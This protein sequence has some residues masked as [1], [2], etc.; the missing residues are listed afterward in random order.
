MNGGSSRSNENELLTWF[1]GADLWIIGETGEIMDRRPVIVWRNL[2]DLFTLKIS[3]YMPKSTTS[4]ERTRLVPIR[5]ASTLGEV[6]TTYNVELIRFG[7]LVYARSE[8]FSV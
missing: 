1:H 7:H 4:V 2:V 6:F 8:G 3:P 5:R